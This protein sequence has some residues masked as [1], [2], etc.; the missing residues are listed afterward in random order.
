MQVHTEGK[1]C[2]FNE[3]EKSFTE[4]SGL[5]RHKNSLEKSFTN[6][7]NG[8]AFT[9]PSH[10]AIHMRTHTGETPYQYKECG[11]ALSN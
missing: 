9:S 10:L 4:S 6:A 3:C 11:K 5:L 8:K 7:K 2:K 1:L